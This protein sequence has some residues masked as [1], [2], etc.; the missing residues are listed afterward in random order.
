MAEEPLAT[1]LAGI[2]AQIEG[3][4]LRG[5]SCEF[6]SNKHET[7]LTW[8]TNRI[9]E[10]TKEMDELALKVE[11]LNELVVELTNRLNQG[12]D[13]LQEPPRPP[14]PTK[15][16]DW[17]F[18]DPNAHLCCSPRRV[19]EPAT[20]GILLQPRHPLEGRAAC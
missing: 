11:E 5:S 9:N 16:V 6:W 19:D 20:Q 14:T 3:C 18:C 10:A 17:G 8:A 12:V 15:P 2:E 7:K 13:P 1:R 4:I